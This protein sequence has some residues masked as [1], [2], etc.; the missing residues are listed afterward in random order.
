MFFGFD[1]SWRWRLR[2]HESKYNTFWIQTMRYLSRGRLIMGVGA[3]W[4]REE[5]A[6]LG[7]PHAERGRM[8]D[9]SLQAARLL[10]TE[11]HCTYEGRHYAFRDVSLVPKARR[12]A[13]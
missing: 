8:T 2:E 10:L 7:L 6:A 9:E 11:D 3:G 13:A 4:M 12:C 1:E 5:F